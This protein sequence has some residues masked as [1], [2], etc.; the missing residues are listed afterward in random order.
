M[1]E[2][3]KVEPGF[4][5]ISIPTQS[6][7]VSMFGAIADPKSAVYN[8]IS[9]ATSEDFRYYGADVNNFDVAEFMAEIVSEVKILAE[10]NWESQ[11]LKYERL[12]YE[13]LIEIGLGYDYTY[14]E[15]AGAKLLSEY[16]SRIQ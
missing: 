9:F 7:D 11:N 1:K 15:E 8:T 10:H 14:Y 4:M 6:Y 12:I 13:S 16:D 3:V 2:F 5:A